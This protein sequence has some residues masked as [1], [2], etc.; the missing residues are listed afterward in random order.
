[1]IYIEN[2]PFVSGLKFRHF[3]GEGD[4]ALLAEVLTA[5]ET[6]DQ[7]DRHVKPDDLAS[8]FQH[9]NNCDPYKDLIIAEVAG[10]VVGYSRGWWEDGVS[11]QRCYIHNGFLIPEWRRQGIGRRILVW[12]EQRL[13]E[14]A[15]T[16]PAELEKLYQVNVTQFQV[17]TAALLEY[18]GYQPVRYYYLM[19]RPNLDDTPENPLPDGLEI[20]PVTPGHYRQIWQLVVET[21]QEEWGHQ[22]LTEEDYQEWLSSP[23]FQP[24]LWQVAWE[25]NTDQVVGEVLAFIHYAEN[26]QF[27][28]QRGYTENIG[29]AHSWRRR[30]VASA[31][32]NRSL[33]AQ[34]AAG[35]TDSAM[36]VDSA[37]LSGATHLYESLGFQI[38]KRDTLYRKLLKA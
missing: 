10:K 29:V 18:S 25:I 14:I 12:L 30:G 7:M 13:R 28:R 24:D 21:S 37:N 26:K 5:S 32:I 9:L 6:A 15:S 22:P 36:A 38:V 16:H 1:M 19:V 3:Q 11:T 35:M 31:L 33:N 2:T 27:N 4:F 34:K 23:E 8:A 17:G 20:R